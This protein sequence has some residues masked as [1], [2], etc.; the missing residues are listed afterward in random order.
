MFKLLFLAT[1]SLPLLACSGSPTLAAPA[2]PAKLTVPAGNKL[3]I[4]MNAEGV[5]IYTCQPKKDDPSKFEWTFKAPDA[6]LTGTDGR[7]GGK[8]YFGPA[9]ESSDGSKVI[10][11]VQS[12]SR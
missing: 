12:Y 2:A 6:H 10:E 11:K 7:D 5:Q 1:L 8:H 9:W 4:V 3:S